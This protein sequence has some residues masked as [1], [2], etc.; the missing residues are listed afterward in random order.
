MPINIRRKDN[1]RTQMLVVILLAVLAGIIG[2]G[3]VGLATR[4][5][6]STP[7]ASARTS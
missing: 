7:A 6:S 1:F 3:L 2:G 5:P 4:H